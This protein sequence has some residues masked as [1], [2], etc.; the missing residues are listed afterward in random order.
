[1]PQAESAL[2]EARQQ[3][4]AAQAQGQALA[5]QEQQ[6]SARQVAVAKAA[7]ESRL[8]LWHAQTTTAICNTVACK[9]CCM[10]YMSSD[11]NPMFEGS[12][13]SYDPQMSV[14]WQHPPILT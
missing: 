7:G 2:A 10:L 1:M 3:L 11:R 9:R 13:S 4:A 5:D 6:L 14:D 8:P 12:D